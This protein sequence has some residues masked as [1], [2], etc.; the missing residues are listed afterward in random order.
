M[1][2]K[3]MQKT[4]EKYKYDYHRNRRSRIYWIEFYFS[5]VKRASGRPHRLSG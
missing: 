5:Y 3:G 4:E 2:L 1:C